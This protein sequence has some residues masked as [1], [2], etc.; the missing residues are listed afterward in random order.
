MKAAIEAMRNE[1]MGS[2][3]ASRVFKLN[4]KYYSIMLKTGRKAQV[5]Q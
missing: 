2:Y 3:K 5:K 4:H 1:E